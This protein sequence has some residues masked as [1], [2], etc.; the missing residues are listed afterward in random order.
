M[1]IALEAQTRRQTAQRSP[2]WERI[3]AGRGI[4]EEYQQ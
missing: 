4:G 3:A 1:E 2:V